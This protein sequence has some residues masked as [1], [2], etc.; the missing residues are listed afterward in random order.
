MKMIAGMRMKNPPAKRKWSGDWFNWTINLAGSVWLRTVRIAAAKT[1]FQE[2]TKV[3]MAEAANPGKANGKATR[4]KASKRPQPM[5]MAASSR[6]LD[7]AM[8]ILL[9]TKMVVGK[10]IAVCMNATPDTVSSIPQR[11]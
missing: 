1:S 11:I 3:N 10:A 2:S 6:S 9:V 7:T 5:V 4:R 8:K